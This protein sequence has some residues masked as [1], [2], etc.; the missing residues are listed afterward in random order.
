M[1]VPDKKVGVEKITD[2]VNL[3]EL[4]AEWKEHD[5]GMDD[6]KGYGVFVQERVQQAEGIE[7]PPV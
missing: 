7:L 2:E 3:N 4:E 1:Q 5:P 6:L